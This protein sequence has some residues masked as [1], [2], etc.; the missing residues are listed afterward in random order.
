MKTPIV[1]EI[2]PGSA[3]SID[4]LVDSQG[5]SDA[6]YIDLYPSI[7]QEYRGLANV[8]DVK[9]GQRLVYLPWSN[10]LL[11]CTDPGV[12]HFV[13]TSRNRHKIS[14]LEQRVL[15]DQGIFCLGLSA[16]YA[17]VHALALEG[18]GRLFILNDFDD[19]SLSN[20]N[21][22][23]HGLG[24]IGKNKAELA[25]Q[26]LWEIDP[27]LDIRV[28]PR[29]LNAVELETVLASSEITLVVEECDDFISKVRVR[30]IA[31]SKGL[32]VF[33]E[34]SDRGTVDVERFDLEPQRP[35][36]HGLLDGLTS[37]QLERATKRERTNLA[38][39]VIGLEGVSARTAASLL[40]YDHSVTSWP[41]LAADVIGG[42]A[43]LAMVIRKHLLG[44]LSASGRLRIDAEHAVV[45]ENWSIVPPTAEALTP[46]CYQGDRPFVCPPAFPSSPSELA[47][48]LAY[49]G[50]LAPSGGNMQP[51]KL[52]ITDDRLAIYVDTPKEEPFLDFGRASTVLAIGAVAANVE[53]ASRALGVSFARVKQFENWAKP[54]VQYT[55][56][57]N[58]DTA[59]LRELQLICARRTSRAIVPRSPLTVQ[60]FERLV[61]ND[62][63]QVTTRFISSPTAM[64]ALGQIV[65][66]ADRLRFLH[67]SAYDEAMHELCWDAEEVLR[68]RD[69]IALGSLELRP[70]DEAVVRLLRHRGAMQFIREHNL[71]SGL[72]S[73][74]KDAFDTGS[75][76]IMVAV[77][78][79]CDHADI[80]LAGCAFEETWLEATRR[81]I[82][83]QP[84]TALPYMAL[85]YRETGESFLK[86]TEDLL[87]RA[88]ELFGIGTDMFPVM[89]AR[90]IEDPPPP[91]SHSARRAPD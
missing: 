58:S 52:V 63:A 46:L 56:E 74:A 54:I 69:G 34:T 16:G 90:V 65:G 75:G 57:W 88:R 80:F 4:A 53:W 38:L 89:I 7:E 3:D 20:L 49:C 91:D 9:I 2:D 39:R 32:P 61:P 26:R 18:T 12:Y 77:P 76:A 40:E 8:E 86:P 64:R 59:D 21:R 1:L 24:D 14:A 60:S 70:G 68:R 44:T 17:V 82:G 83:V 55:F 10:R 35:I 73:L 13:R 22:L 15:H 45:S 28:I 42:G 48:Y 37:D 51:W 78:T 81:N 33:M 85:R 41:Q 43:N 62:R 79:R 67:R 66:D 87:G 36:L 23:G 47:Q 72:R 11:R 25:A 71:G 27:F 19:L 30:E 31:R 84:W 5:W 6:E 29:K 50:N